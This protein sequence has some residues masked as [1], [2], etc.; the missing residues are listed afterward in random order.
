MAAVP[1]RI[2]KETQKLAQEP[3]MFIHFYVLFAF[4]APGI[5]AEP[6]AENYRYFHVTMEGPS[7]T[8]YEGMDNLNNL[9]LIYSRNLRTGTIPPGSI[10]HGATQGEI[11]YQNLPSEYR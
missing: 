7:G 5:N 1:K 11:S 4:V 3:R 10:P 6:D 2:E 8:P 9:F